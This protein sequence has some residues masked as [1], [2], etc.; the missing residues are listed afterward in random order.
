MPAKIKRR[1]YRKESCIIMAT[2]TNVTQKRLW[3][4]IEKIFKTYSHVMYAACITSFTLWLMAILH[5]Y[6]ICDQSMFSYQSD[7]SIIHNCGGW[8]GAYTAAA[9]LYVFGSSSYVLLLFL[10]FI[11]YFKLLRLNFLTELDRFVA[12]F[13]CIASSASLCTRYKLSLFDHSATGG[14][15]GHIVYSR[16]LR[17]CDRPIATL[18][19]LSLTVATLIIIFRTLIV[20]CMRCCHIFYIWMAKHKEPLLKTC[21]ALA[22]AIYL[23][24]YPLLKLCAY[25]CSVIANSHIVASIKL[26]L[27]EQ[28]RNKYQEKLDSQDQFWRAYLT[29][30]AQEEAPSLV[31]IDTQQ[32][33]KNN[34]AWDHTEPEPPAATQAI[35]SPTPE[36]EETPA[37]Q[38][39]PVSLLSGNKQ[40]QSDKQEIAELKDK[41]RLLEEKLA[42]FGITGSVVAIKRGPVVTL[43]EYQPDINAR[44][45][46]ITAL[47]DDLALALQA[48]SIRTIAPI[49]GTA[50]IGFEVA[51]STRHSVSFGNCVQSTAFT[52]HQG[53]LPLALGVDTTGNNLVVDLAK[54]PHLLIAG[55]TG[56]GKSVALH[57]MIISLLLKKTPD[58]LK[59]VLIDPK[60]LEFAT[61]ADC[62]HLLFPIVMQPQQTIPVLKW[63]VQ[64]MEE[65][66][67]IMTAAGARNIGDYQALAKHNQTYSRMPFMVVVIDELADLMM[68]CGRDIEDLIARIAQMA[69][70]AGI[71]M[72]LATQRPSVD[73]ITGLIKVNF[74]S[75]ISCRVTSKID[76]RTILD[77]NG[78]EK[79]LGR[80]DMLFLDAADSTIKRVHGC[81]ISDAEIAAVIHHVRKQQHPS[82]VPTHDLIA[83]NPQNMDSQDDKLY[84][85]VINFLKDV[86]E[87][88]ISLLQRRFKIGYNRSA[89]II[90]C[91]ETQGIVAPS[92]GG[93][94]RKVIHHQ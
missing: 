62:P 67:A 47:E 36:T 55:S 24:V 33:L 73:V 48:M 81:Y 85:E 18:I 41:A 82:Y 11:A 13:L 61:Y 80:G 14:L 1:T 25:A 65:R 38:L 94:L 77:C 3:P 54:M 29:E 2:R 46:K 16:L 78:A 23:I 26:T 49:P 79:L 76:S 60:R 59:I 9:I 40:V 17:V 66:Y 19:I 34:S 86:D 56:S 44:I 21:R 12:F 84:K 88:S 35:R 39:P 43:L 31:P 53:A 6:A 8:L 37:Y 93:K 75:R 50:F 58:E 22:Y 27:N 10:F 87:V 45:S 4:I 92:D 64:Q 42:H 68:T 20:Q 28:F 5:T 32:E 83:Q 91:L 7:Q 52:G 70:A 74:P 15:I 69:R 57:T 71:H 72:I 30:M 90:D 51:N 89:R 63:V